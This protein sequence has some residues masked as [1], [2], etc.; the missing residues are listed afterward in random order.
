MNIKPKNPLEES[1]DE[2][3]TFSWATSLNQ[4]C[5]EEWNSCFEEND[6]L[7]CYALAKAIANSHLEDIE[8]HY[9]LGTLVGRLILVT[10]CFS[11]TT[12]LEVLAPKSIQN[13]ISKVRKYFPN[14]L[15]LKSFIVGT[16]LAICKDSLGVKN[17]PKSQRERFFRLLNGK[18]EAKAKQ[19]KAHV[20]VIKEIQDCDLEIIESAISS[21]FQFYPSMPSAHLEIDTSTPYSEKLRSS[22][23][24]VYKKRR[25]L[26]NNSSNRWVLLN[27]ITECQD[28]LYSL[29]SQMVTN[30]DNNFNT[31]TAECFSQILKQLNNN[32]FCLV[33]RNQHG[34]YLAFA[35]ALIQNRKLY[36][37]Y[38]GIDRKKRDQYSLYY[39][40]LYRLIDEAELKECCTINL[41]QTAYEAKSLI[42]ASFK[43]LFL[44]V[45][46]LTLSTW[47]ILKIASCILFPK[48]VLPTHHVFRQKN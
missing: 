7:N 31:L 22:Y 2:N 37:L 18:W 19:L 44:G 45:R 39:N 4:I 41:G 30:S 24:N 29:Y 12:A 36:P 10:P 13:L 21:K 3:I 32:S 26:F 27:E 17:I 14:F 16:P 5:P 9:L 47:I 6:V 35:I 42:G 48:T 28:K 34:E 40:L 20:V 43:N 15:K 38:C 23:R 25:S 46:P 8:F 1:L 33:A 11:Y